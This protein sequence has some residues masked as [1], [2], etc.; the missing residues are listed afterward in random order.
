M[1]WWRGQWTLR[2]MLR[3]DP[4]CIANER[5]GIA[6]VSKQCRFWACVLCSP[7]DLHQ[8]SFFCRPFYRW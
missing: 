8:A 4:P 1:E 7:D 2:L 3:K 5:A 6:T